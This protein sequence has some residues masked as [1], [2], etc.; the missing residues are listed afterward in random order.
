[1]IRLRDISLP[2]VHTA[3]ALINTAAKLLGVSPHDFTSFTIAR[4]SLDARK[5]DQLQWVYSV[6]VTLGQGE[7]RALRRGGSKASLVQEYHYQIPHPGRI[8]DLRPV[9]VGFGPGGMF[10]ALVLAE[11]GL[12][13]IV[14]ERGCDAQTRHRRVEEFWKT[15]VLD[16]QTNVQFGE[17]GA[18]A[19]SDGKLNTGTSDPRNHWVLQQL[20]RFGAQESILYDAKPHVGT[21]VLLEVIQNLRRRVIEL[22]GEVRFCHKLTRLKTADGRLR[23]VITETPEG[24][25][26]LPCQRLILATG[27]SARD[28]FRMLLSQGILLEPKP[29][30]MGVRIE[31]LQE[32]VNESQYGKPHVPGLPPADYKLF[33]HI[34]NKTVYSFC[35]C[36]GGHVVGAASEE[37]SVVTNGMSYSRR[38]GKNANAALLVS[39]NPQEFPYEGVLGGMQWQEELERRAYAMSGSYQAPAQRVEDFLCHRASGGFGDISPTYR[40]GVVPCDLHTLLPAS[41]TEPMAEGITALSRKLRCFALPDGVLT[42]PETRSSSPVRIWRGADRQSTLEGLYPCGEGAG[43]AGGILSAAADGI[44]CAEA[45]I[46]RCL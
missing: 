31:H 36:P 27:H 32:Q 6:D 1:M 17:G 7:Q 29:F 28:T 20:V 39:L 38:D 34:G 43:Y 41:I 2:P 9:V 35:M 24:T 26:E 4:K 19:F 23:G 42:G 46:A 13:P 44:R 37:G 5:K 11:A 14:L 40:P 10:A 12:R 33:H 45:L 22:G 8:P 21:D 25:R 3:Q 30:A 16:T 18:G 15:G